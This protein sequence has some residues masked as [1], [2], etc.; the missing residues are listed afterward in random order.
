LKPD[1]A[2][3][4][5][6]FLERLRVNPNQNARVAVAIGSHELIGITMR[7]SGRATTASCGKLSMKGT[8]IPVRW[9]RLLGA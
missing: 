5:Q 4:V 6:L 8:L 1:F 9:K 2:G 3:D 7:F